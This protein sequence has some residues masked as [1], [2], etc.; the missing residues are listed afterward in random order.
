MKALTSESKKKLSHRSFPLLE[1]YGTKMSLKPCEDEYK[2]FFN[3]LAF[4]CQ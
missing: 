3:E 4:F 1:V 2:F